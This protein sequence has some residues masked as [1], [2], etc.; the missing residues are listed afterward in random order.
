MLFRPYELQDPIVRAGPPA[1][2]VRNREKLPDWEP[3]M[4][5]VKCHHFGTAEGRFHARHVFIAFPLVPAHMGGD[6]RI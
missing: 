3:A 2:S 1:R 6:R 4:T 5:C